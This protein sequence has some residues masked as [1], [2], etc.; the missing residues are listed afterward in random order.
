MLLPEHCFK[1]KTMMSS[2]EWEVQLKFSATGNPQDSGFENCRGAH[3]NAPD[4][5][6]LPVSPICMQYCS[7]NKKCSFLLTIFFYVLPC[8]ATRALFSRTSRATS[9]SLLAAC[10]L[11]C[12]K[13]LIVTL[14]NLCYL[15]HVIFFSRKI[16]NQIWKWGVKVFPSF[17]Q[18]FQSFSGTCTFTKWTLRDLSLSIKCI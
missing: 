12:Y 16:C 2:I 5:S 10:S 13:E 15:K 17:Y 9:R 7:N 8:N 6:L 14:R 11:S 1:P 4:C 3:W 18:V